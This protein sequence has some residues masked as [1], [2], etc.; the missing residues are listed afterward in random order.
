VEVVSLS[1]EL[2]LLI[3]KARELEA[4]ERADL[5]KALFLSQDSEES[6]FELWR[7]GTV[8]LREALRPDLGEGSENAP[9]SYQKNN[10]IVHRAQVP[11]LVAQIFQC[12][13]L[14][15]TVGYRKNLLLD[16]LSHIMVPVAAASQMG[17]VPLE[18]A[19]KHGL[20]D[21]WDDALES[22]ERFN[23]QF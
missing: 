8:E 4:G 21:T 9:S 7:N 3:Q 18:L 12:D 14:M 5:L 1:A 22:I 2:D 11:P 17:I 16:P 13:P 23:E 19:Q 6:A 15:V 10:A 20:W